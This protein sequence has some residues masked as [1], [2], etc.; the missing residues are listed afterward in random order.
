MMYLFRRRSPV[1]RWR[2]L[3]L[4]AVC[5]GCGS[6]AE[7]GQRFDAGQQSP[8]DAASV[9]DA[10]RTPDANTRE[11]VRFIVMGDGG[12]G[13]ATQMAVAM[14]V[15]AECDRRGGC[16]F[17]LYLGDNIYDT[18]AAAVDDMQFMTK[19]EIPYAIL[20][21]PFYVVLGNHD[22]GGGGAGF[23][24]WKGDVQVEY[25]Q[26]STKWTLPSHYYAQE[27]GVGATTVEIFGLDTNN[28][29]YLGDDTQ[30]AWLDGATAASS[31]RW[32]LAFGHHTYISNGSHGNAGE[33]EG[34]PFIPIVS[35]GSVKSFFDAHVCGAVDVYF[36]GHDHNRQWLEPT[37]GTEFIVSGT[38]AKTTG[39]AGRGTPTFFETDEK[40]GF[41]LVEIEGDTFAGWF[42]DED[43]TLE[44]TRSFRK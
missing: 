1:S 34:I 33:Y 13:N 7:P 38:A 37:C 12:E 15:D 11:V 42:Y 29:M 17:A 21:F 30:A 31:A 4:A 32:K 8:A 28:I 22:Y 2:A 9:S 24:F 41:M 16:A 23:E 14:A 19:F 25:T 6:S 10:A 43:G 39:L 35:G 18:G 44:Y 27:V 26:E 36:A 20:D 3:A 40:G 5:A